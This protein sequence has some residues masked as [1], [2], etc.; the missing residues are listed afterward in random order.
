[1]VALISDKGWSVEDIDHFAYHQSD[2]ENLLPFYSKY[3]D[4][5]SKESNDK[6]DENDDSYYSLLG[7]RREQVMRMLSLG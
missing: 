3:A 5:E 1:M 2:L 4:K 6:D 7:L